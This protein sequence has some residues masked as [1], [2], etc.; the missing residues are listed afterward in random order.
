MLGVS[1]AA[2]IKSRGQIPAVDCVLNTFLWNKQKQSCVISLWILKQSHKVQR[3]YHPWGN[4]FITSVGIR[5]QSIFRRQM[6]LFKTLGG[7]TLAFLMDSWSLMP[8]GEWKQTREPI[9]HEDGP[10]SDAWQRRSDVFI[11]LSLIKRTTLDHLQEFLSLGA[12][13][14]G[15]MSSWFVTRVLSLVS[16]GADLHSS[17]GAADAETET[18]RMSDV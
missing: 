1:W 14:P 13:V 15:R 17:R 18:S 7:K 4:I 10:D 8:P 12:F 3:C 16:L 5:L 2:L 11:G 6:F 9:D